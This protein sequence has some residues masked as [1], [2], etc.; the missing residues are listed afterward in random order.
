MRTMLQLLLYS[1]KTNLIQYYNARLPVARQPQP[2]IKLFSGDTNVVCN[3]AACVI[4][5]Q[6]TLEPVV[7]GHG[8]GSK[9]AV[10][11]DKIMIGNTG[12]AYK[13]AAS[14]ISSMT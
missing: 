13:V 6:E 11:S 8:K 9:A 7:R 10:T 14:V 12:V 5:E 4:Q 1:C 3:I 2:M